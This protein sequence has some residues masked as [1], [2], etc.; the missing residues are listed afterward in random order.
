MKKTILGTFSAV[1]VMAL[2][3]VSC[4]GAST[5]KTSL[6]NSVDSVSYAYGVSMTD[7]GL[8]QFLE[9]SGVLQSTSGIEYDYQMR[10]ASADSTQKEVLQKEMNAKVDSINKINAPRLNQFIKGLTEAMGLEENSAY[11]NGLSIGVQ[12][13]QQMLPQFNEMLFGSDSTKSVNKDQVLAGII[14]AL[15][16]QELAI[17]KMEASGMVQ[18]AAEKAQAEQQVRQEEELKAQH[19]ESIAAGDAFMAENGAKEGVV[20]LP[21]GLQYEIVRAGNGP[22]PTETD[23]VKVHYHGTLIDG[24]VFDSSVDRGEPA[25]FGVNQVIAGWTEALKL[26]PVGSKWR[27]YVPYDLAYGSADRGTIKP[28]SNLIFDVELLSIEK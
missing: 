26:M 12:F 23:R 25:T 24:T 6:K 1:A 16:N 15:K 3:M 19:Q 5:P 28:F 14:S 8:V 27:L 13:S 9:Q 20:T 11:G 10:I 17:S 22:M 21:S 18:S 4:G 2:M 7:Q